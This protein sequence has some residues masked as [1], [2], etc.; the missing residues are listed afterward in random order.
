MFLVR[1][2]T[3]VYRVQYTIELQIPSYNTIG[4][5]QPGLSESAQPSHERNTHRS[6]PYPR[7]RRHIKPYTYTPRPDQPKSTQ[8]TF[9]QGNHN[10]QQLKTVTGTPRSAQAQAWS[11]RSQKRPSPRTCQSPRISPDPRKKYKRKSVTQSAEGRSILSCNHLPQRKQ[12]PSLVP[13]RTLVEL[14]RLSSLRF[15]SYRR[16]SVLN[17]PPN[18]GWWFGIPH[19]GEKA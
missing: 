16:N 11:Q 4:P 18:Q 1:Y 13:R 12:K 7:H 10:R 17:T 19:P 3:P 2:S 9:P 6:H 8:P 15:M 14:S 5:T